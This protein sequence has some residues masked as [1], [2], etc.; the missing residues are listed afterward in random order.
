M[1]GGARGSIHPT[2][3]RKGLCLWIVL[4]LL[5]LP[6]CGNDVDESDGDLAPVTVRGLDFSFEPSDLS[7]PADTPVVVRLENIGA[8]EHNFVV[9]AQGVTIQSETDYSEEMAIF[10]LEVGPG[11]GV[12][13]TLQ[14]PA[15]TYQVICSI[16][17]HFNA[18][19]EA[20]LVVGGG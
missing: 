15:G 13:G 3:K 19:M 17:G 9:L 7:I 14:L 8:V 2:V 10:A 12:S 20:R 16:P 1:H 6:G 11:G 4:T 5:L 18:G